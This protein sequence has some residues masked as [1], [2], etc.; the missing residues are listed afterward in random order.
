MSLIC[1]ALCHFVLQ[2]S[3]MV[4]N[5][6]LMVFMSVAQAETNMIN[7]KTNPQLNEVGFPALTMCKRTAKRVNMHLSESR[8]CA[9]LQF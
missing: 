2:T 8:P 6:V 9:C 4:E 1:Y 5:D 3:E 7:S